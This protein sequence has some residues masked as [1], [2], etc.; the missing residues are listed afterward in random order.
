MTADIIQQ[1]RALCQ[2]LLLGATLGIT[3]DLFRILRVRVHLPL[4]GPLLD[5]LF[6]LLAT[7]ALF[8][9][10][11]QAWGGQIRLYGG[12]FCLIGG[13]AYF[14]L[15]SPWMLKLGY[16][17]ADLVTLF[18]EILTYPVGVAKALFKKIKK[19]LQNTFHSGVKWYRIKKM[20]K[21]LDAAARRRAARER[22]GSAYAVQARRLSHQGGDSGPSDLHG[23]HA[24]G[25][26]G[27]DSGGPGAAGRPLPAGGGPRAG[28]PS[29]VRRH[30]PQRRS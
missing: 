18:L 13:G 3:Y 21:E 23:N 17:A 12:V 6:W 22:G 14:W 4:L 1:S 8:L 9:W 11:Q 25:P 10:S 2:A 20:P 7:A 30:R 27:A 5:L 16:L 24:A 29:V 26:A 15:A 28:K 19:I